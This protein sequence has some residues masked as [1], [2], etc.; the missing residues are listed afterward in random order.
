M[1][2][3]LSLVLALCISILCLVSPCFAKEKVWRNP[4]ADITTD[5][6]YFNAVKFSNIN[7][8]F[9]GMTKTAFEPNTS[10]SRAMFV[11][12]LYNLAGKLGVNIEVENDGEIPFRDVVKGEWYES[13]VEWA[14][15][16]GLVYGV[17]SDVFGLKADVTR[18]QMCALLYRFSQKAS[19]TLSEIRDI[20]FA[21]ED[22]ISTYAKD[23]VITMGKAWVVS[24]M[25][26]GIFCPAGSAN[27]AQV[28][29]I[30]RAFVN[31]LSR[32]SA[33]LGDIDENTLDVLPY[34]VIFDND[35]GVFLS[36]DDSSL[37][38]FDDYDTV[39][40][41]AQ[42]FSKDSIATLHEDGHTVYTY[43]NIGSLENFRDFYEDF[44]D[45]TLGE[46][47]NWPGEYWVDTSKGEWQEH[48]ASLARKYAEKGVDGFFVDNLDVYS[49]YS[50][51]EIYDGVI[52]MLKD[53]MSLNIDVVVNG[54]IDVVNRYMNIDKGL[55]FDILTGI[56]QESVF[57]TILDFD[58]DIFG[59]Q[60]PSNTNAYIKYLSSCSK[61]G[62]EIY[63]LEY[64]KDEA[65]K[66]RIVDYCKQ[67]GWYY[68]ISSS[69]ELG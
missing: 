20:N 69:V 43:I 19:V 61:Y 60:S 46:Y 24:G 7:G 5:A 30:M 57:A 50:R 4:F 16:R 13:A 63:L 33:D 51:K 67:E 49:V 11:R 2:R 8:L 40:I 14:Y 44:K 3:A 39:I 54:G 29:Q 32:S 48:I 37:E 15:T 53:L 25:G 27:R 36:R 35:Y 28:A 21:D 10:M 31:C 47:E 6:W 65:L 9:S 66:K 38:I 41:D 59:E 52:T 42:Y 22:E 17:E 18:E 56:N 26:D 62:V 12:V 45:I 55:P 34:P 64:T 68:Y 58:K 1:K 23:A